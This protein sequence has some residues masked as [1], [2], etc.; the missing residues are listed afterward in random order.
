MAVIGV[1]VIPIG[2]VLEDHLRKTCVARAIPWRGKDGI[3]AYNDALKEAV[4]PLPTWRRIQVVGDHR[5]AGAHGGHDAANLKQ[6]DV[7]DDLG[8]VRKFLA[9]YPA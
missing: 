7:D 5:N 1:G 6:G 3:T 2:G 8:W 9:E 4:Y